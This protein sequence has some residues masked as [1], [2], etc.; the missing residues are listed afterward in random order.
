PAN[1]TLGFG[2]VIAVSRQGS[3]RQERL[4]Y[5]A[6]LTDIDI[7]IP[8]QPDWSDEDIEKIRKKD[9]SK[10]SRGSARAWLGHL[11]ALRWFM[12]SNLD[13]AVIIEDDVDW[14][15]HLRS[16]QKAPPN[17][18]SQN[19][20]MSALIDNPET[21]YWGHPSQWEILYLGHCGDFFSANRLRNNLPHTTIHDTTL[22]PVSHLHVRTRKF[23]KDLQLPHQSRL[24]HRS[25][26]PLC[27]FAYAVNRKSAER[28]LEEF[29]K[30]GDEGTPAYDVRILE[31]CR[32]L[33]WLCYSVNPELFHHDDGPSEIAAVNE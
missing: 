22:P 25:V 23:W 6:N 9:G 30:E 24:V 5:A 33:G 12:Q 4:L 26:W 32:D 13:T 19:N 20:S 8:T 11:H 10:I 18:I 21:D 28:I 27:T 15:I 29:D 1:A 31:A 2:T 14:D 3:K 17:N 16:T 7:T